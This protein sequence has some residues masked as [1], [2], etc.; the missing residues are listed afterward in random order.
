[1]DTNLYRET[2]KDATK[3]KYGQKQML[4]SRY[5]PLQPDSAE[6]DMMRLSNSYMI[7]VS[8]ELKEVLPDIMQVYR[9]ET[10]RT[11]SR[12]DGLFN[13]RTAMTNKLGAAL[14]NILKKNGECYVPSVLWIMEK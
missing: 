9:M 6:R 14:D 13:L 2:V 4:K 12:M 11:D 8:K 7:M 1:M 5:V 10:T 3:E